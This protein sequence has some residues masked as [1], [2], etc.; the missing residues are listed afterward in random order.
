MTTATIEAKISFQ[1]RGIPRSPSWL[2][3]MGAILTSLVVI[4]Y[5]HADANQQAPT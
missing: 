4:T 2:Q 5:S 1:Q 3:S